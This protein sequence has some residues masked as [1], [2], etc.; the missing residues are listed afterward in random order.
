MFYICFQGHLHT[1]QDRERE[2]Y[3]ATSE[4]QKMKYFVIWLVPQ[5]GE[6]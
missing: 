3:E 2:S 5:G 6:P 4:K 1:H